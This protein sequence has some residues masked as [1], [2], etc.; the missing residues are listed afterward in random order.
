MSDGQIHL[1]FDSSEIVEELRRLQEYG[2]RTWSHCNENEEFPGQAIQAI[3]SW[4]VAVED[5]LK[6]LPEAE[7]L[8]GVFRSAKRGETALEFFVTLSNYRRQLASILAEFENPPAIQA[9]APAAKSSEADEATLLRLFRCL[10]DGARTELIRDTFK[11]L[12]P[13]ADTD[14]D[15]EAFLR[16]VRPWDWPGRQY[17]V[18]E[19]LSDPGDW[20]NHIL[21]E[22]EIEIL[23]GFSQDDAN[24]A[25]HMA[26]Q[27]YSETKERG[28]DPPS[29]FTLS[30]EKIDDI[31]LFQEDFMRFV[32]HWREAA[33]KELGAT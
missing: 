30:G 10:K 22:P 2:E 16:N 28:F 12:V 9:K 15:V 14:D 17:V 3:D 21:G 33:L 8:L 5:Y 23:F 26:E 6:N 19:N 4:I 11:S 27:Y 20:L 25:R 24:T 1:I 18:L 32:A 7:R 31:A 13:F 29:A